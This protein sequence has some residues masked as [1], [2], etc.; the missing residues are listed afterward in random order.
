MR[1]FLA[2][3]FDQDFKG[4]ISDIIRAV[5]PFTPSARFTHISNIHLTLVFL[6]ETEENKL[7]AIK[8]IMEGVGGPKF[9]LSVDRMGMFKGGLLWLGIKENR[10]LGSLY[11]G[12]CRGLCAEGFKIEDR[13]YKPHITIAREAAISRTNIEKFN[14]SFPAIEYWPLS[15][16]LMLSRTV[17]GRLTYTPL[18]SKKLG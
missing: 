2:I 4:K 12:L 14:E 1:L 13:E 6:G 7:Q 8:N 16:E 11:G 15:Y 3:N 10:A 17:G 18:Y 5:S 9:A